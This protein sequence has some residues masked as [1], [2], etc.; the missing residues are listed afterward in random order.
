MSFRLIIFVYYFVSNLIKTTKKEVS[1]N[2]LY[3]LYSFQFF[4]P[5]VEES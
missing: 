4:L 3:E 5:A 2:N 1:A